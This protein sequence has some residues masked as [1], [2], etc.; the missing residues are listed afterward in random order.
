M[1]DLLH[2]LQGHD[3]GFLQMLA[4]LW[5][6][7]ISSP[8]ASSALPI[9]VKELIQ[10][11]LVQEIIDTLPGPAQEALGALIENE[12]RLAW[13]LFTRRY[14]EVRA[15]GAARRDRERPDLNPASPTEILWYRGLIGQA[16]LNTPIEPQEYAYIPEDLLALIHLPGEHSESPYGRPASPL[17][18]KHPRLTNDR[19]LDHACTLLAALRMQIP[20]EDIPSASWGI[21]RHD[22]QELLASANLLDGKQ[23]PQL[24]PVR[25]F[26]ET[27]RGEAL[28]RLAAAWMRST[29]FNELQMLPGLVCEGEWSNDPLLA[30]TAVMEMLSRLPHNSWWSLEA[31]LAEVRE[32]TPDFQRPAGDYD[33]WFIRKAGSEQYLRGF[34]AWD[35]VDGALLRYLICGPL[36]WLGFLDL[37][38]SDPESPPTAFRTSAW[39]EDLWLEK[40]P[41][42]LAEE[43]EPVRVNSEGKII[44]PH[45]APRAIRYQLAR[46]S[47]WLLE[48]KDVYHYILTPTTLER[49][50][51]QGLRPSHLVNLLRKHSTDPLPP[52]VLQFL[53]RWEQHGVQ[54]KIQPA[55][56]LRVSSPEILSALRKTRAARFLGEQLSETIVILQ[57]G[58][59]ERVLRALAEIGFL[60]EISQ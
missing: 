2:T 27:P 24:E 12:G 36:H 25:N 42:G 49:A 26:L 50:R 54:A 14:G 34:S 57:P 11:A 23:R 20:V 43:K 17:E 33:S 31:F 59:E 60:G 19:I 22:L 13:S 30:R 15:M 29:S 28:S 5:G 46:F 51:Q 41:Q 9:L 6:I 4:G 45:L 48:E 8:D 35:E 1:P 21:P 39:A 52:S 44:V 18:S 3:M 7:E 32:R 10:P 55:S 47:D 53:E 16:F 37:A 58:S 38:A 40:P 56:F